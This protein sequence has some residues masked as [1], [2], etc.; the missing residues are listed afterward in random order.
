MEVKILQARIQPKNYTKV[1]IRVPAE[2]AYLFK[3]KNLSLEQLA[4]LLYPHIQDGEISNGKAT[5]VM[6][7]SKMEL[8]DF[9]GELG[10][11]YFNRTEEDLEH[12]IQVLKNLRYES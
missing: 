5:E 2:L 12:D 11:S 9:Y 8:L 4:L 6:G 10:L 3:N 1:E 7:T